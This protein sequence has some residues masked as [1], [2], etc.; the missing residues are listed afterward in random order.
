MWERGDYL[1]SIEPE[2]L[3]L[4]VIHRFLSEEAY[5]SP[6]VAREVV[7]RSIEQSLNFGVYRGDEQVGFARVVTDY[8]TF[9]WLAD[10]FVLE[11]HRGQGLGKWLVATVLG[12]PEL[13]DLRRWI[14][15]T[16]DA[17]G[18]YERFGFRPSDDTRFMVRE[19]EAARN[20]CV[21]GDRP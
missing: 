12:A 5:W 14:L 13:Q 21:D 18:L 20:A 8:V 1:I 15:G 2:R 3:D 4:E 11:G 16:A 17:H 6:G 10:V 19:T 9:A 7:E